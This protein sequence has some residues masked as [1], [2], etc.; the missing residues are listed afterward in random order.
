MTWAS[1]WQSAW[2]SAWSAMRGGTEATVSLPGAGSLVFTGYAPT[3]EASATT[4]VVPRF[5]TI[6]TA[7]RDPRAID[8][9]AVVSRVVPVATLPRTSRAAVIGHAPTVETQH[10]APV[11]S[12]G[13]LEFI[14]YAPSVVASCIHDETE[15]LHDILRLL[16]AANNEVYARSSAPR[17]DEEQ[18]LEDIL[19][20]LA[21]ATR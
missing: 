8:L 15:D 11:A 13:A 9:R 2:E 16:A 21:V 20:L 19:L 12:A 7:R 14:G 10:P 1:A 18:D 6:P 3:V 4:L 5:A 17:I